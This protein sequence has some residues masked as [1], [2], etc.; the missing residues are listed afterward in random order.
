MFDYLK[1]PDKLLYDLVQIPGVSVKRINSRETPL[2]DSI[3]DYAGIIGSPSAALVVARA[4]CDKI[5]VVAIP[6]CGRRDLDDQAWSFG[7]TEGVVVLREG[8]RLQTKHLVVP[9]KNCDKRTRVD[10]VLQEL[11]LQRKEASI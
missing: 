7:Y 8:E 3:C 11:L 1:W 2:A 5:F 9:D 4:V 6:D 10:V